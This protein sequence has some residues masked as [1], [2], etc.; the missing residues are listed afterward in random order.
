M[1]INDVLNILL[2]TAIIILLLP[3][4]SINKQQT[5]QQEKSTNDVIIPSKEKVV[6]KPNKFG[7]VMTFPVVIIGA[8]VNG[9]PNF[10]TAAW[11]GIVNSEPPM[12]TL[13]VQDKRFTMQGITE[14]QTFSVNFPSE[15]MT[16]AADYVGTVSGK[17]IDKTGIFDVFYGQS[18]TSP[19]ISEAPVSFECKV[20]TEVEGWQDRTHHIIIAEITAIHASDNIF[21]NGKPDIRKISPIITAPGGKYLGIGEFVGARIKAGESFIQKRK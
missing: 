15:R 9:K 12:L 10:M 6:L 5:Q 11:V 2:A 20:V 8:Q 3:G 13:G 14:N 18:S 7:S 4:T 1:K 19:M 17:D 16:G 21:T